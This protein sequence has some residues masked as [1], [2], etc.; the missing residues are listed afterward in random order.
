MNLAE[1]VSWATPTTMTVVDTLPKGV[2]YLPGT[3]FYGGTYKANSTP[4]YPG[5]VEGGR[6]EEPEI[7]VNGD[8]TTTLTWKISGVKVGKNVPKIFFKGRIDSKTGNNVSFVNKAGISTTEDNRVQTIQRGNLAE[9]GIKT[10]KSSDIALV[11]KTDQTTYNPNKPIKYTLE[12]YNN[13][14]T[15]KKKQ[16]MMDTFPASG[17]PDGSN[18][19]GEFKVINLKIVPSAGKTL[20]DYEVYYSKDKSVAGKVS[21]DFDYDEIKVG[22]SG[23]ATWHKMT[24]A[25][26]GTVTGYGDGKVSG[27]IMLGDVKG[28]KNAKMMVDCSAEGNQPGEKYVNR[29]SMGTATIVNTSY[30]VKRHLNG[31]VWQDSNLDGRR[32]DKEKRVRGV[33]VTLVDLQTGQVAKNHNGHECVAMTDKN[34]Y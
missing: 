18:F 21:S 7:K 29:A 1:G 15:D 22:S 3:S 20:A 9:A 6:S 32:G 10:S 13:G 8:G 30:V 31:T 16:I 34:G 23:G 11:K 14:K 27:I 26:D 33:M 24:V 2:S 19:S 12:F 28:G 25:S 17:D 4:G 5:T